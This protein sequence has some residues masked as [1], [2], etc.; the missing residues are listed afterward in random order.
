M[1]YQ[2]FNKKVFDYYLSRSSSTFFTLSIDANE[3]NTLITIKE[4]NQFK[5]L[6]T[7]WNS[8]IDDKEGIPQYFGLISIQCFAASLMHEDE[9]NSAE[10]NQIRLCE[11]L[12]LEELSLLQSLFKGG[13]II[14]PIQEQIWHSAKL[15]LQKNLNQNLDLPAK[16]NYAG[17]ICSIS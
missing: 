9:T 6:K 11:I 3:F 16:I 14:N 10:A 4:I 2:E 12:E 13:D 8:L 15:F 17:E 1:T 5:I 7:S